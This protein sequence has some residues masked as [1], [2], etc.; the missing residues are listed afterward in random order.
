MYKKGSTFT[1]IYQLRFQNIED[2]EKT[3]GKTLV[4]KQRKQNCIGN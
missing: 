3:E 2:R 4:G 1:D